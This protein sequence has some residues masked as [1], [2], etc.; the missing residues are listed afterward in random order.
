MKLVGILQYQ[1]SS[2]YGTSVHNNAASR[3]I[4]G[5]NMKLVGIFQYQIS[6]Q[7]GTSVQHT[8]LVCIFQSVRRNISVQNIQ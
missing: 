8:R 3:N 2:Q 6:S 4:L 7:Y 5:S 1:I